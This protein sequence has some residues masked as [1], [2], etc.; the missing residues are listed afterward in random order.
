M[1]LVS[2]KIDNLVPDEEQAERIKARLEA[3]A[4]TYD[5]APNLIPPIENR[6]TQVVPAINMFDLCAAM[7]AAAFCMGKDPNR[8][9]PSTIAT[10]AR[11]VAKNL[12]NEDGTP[13]KN[14]FK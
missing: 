3:I 5:K 12:F 11:A 9:K 7:C 6:P 10:N 13:I 1:G 2:Q 4:A 8:V 14:G